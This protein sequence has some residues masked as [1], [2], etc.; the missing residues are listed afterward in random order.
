M[1]KTISHDKLFKELIKTFFFEFIELFLPELAADIEPDSF[2]FLDK[3]LIANVRDGSVLEADIVVKCRF[4][5][6]DKHFLIHIENQAYSAS[7]FARR[8]FIYFARFI[9]SSGLDVYPIVLFTFDAPLRAEPD[10]Y[11]VHFPTLEVLT[12]RYHTI[13]LNR[14]NWRDFILRPNPIAAALMSKMNFAPSE[15]LYV[16]LECLRLL[17]TLKLN[18][19]KSRLIYGFVD[20]Y[21]KLSKEESIRFNHEFEALPKEEKEPMLELSNH[22]IEKGE[23]LG[24]AKGKRL[25][26]VEGKRLGIAEG[27]RLGIVEGE[28]L[29]LYN[30][31]MKLGNQKFGDPSENVSSELKQIKEASRLATLCERLNEVGSWQDLLAN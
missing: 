26:I 10:S 11:K 25:G 20:S 30:L 12:F 1:A 6:T 17:A 24:L 27:E 5:G 28:R 2:E 21:L 15:R 9:E 3:E 19:A 22:F 29:G 14:L 31:L 18:P 16:K 13:Q 7:D 4:R 23:K 8:M